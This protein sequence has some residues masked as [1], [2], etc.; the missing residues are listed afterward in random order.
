MALLRVFGGSRTQAARLDAED[1]DD[2]LKGATDAAAIGRLACAA[3]VPSRAACEA[4]A[5]AAA[6]TSAAV[7]LREAHRA[8]GFMLLNGDATLAR[9]SPA[10]A[11]FHLAAAALGGDEHALDFVGA[12]GDARADRAARAAAARRS[13]RAASLVSLALLGAA[14]ANVYLLARRRR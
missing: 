2:F 6:P 3:A 1:V 10:A 13:R 4:R 8:L 9:P 11:V 14:V 7:L 5:A 12:V